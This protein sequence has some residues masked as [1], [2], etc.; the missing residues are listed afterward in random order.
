VRRSRRSRRRI[1]YDR[2]APLAIDREQAGPAT[3]G[4][5]LGAGETL[6][7]RVLIVSSSVVFAQERC[8]RPGLPDPASVGVALEAKGAVPSG[9]LR[10]PLCH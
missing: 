1:A 9:A 3:A 8:H 6:R 5:A 2:P 7:L 10:L 4:G